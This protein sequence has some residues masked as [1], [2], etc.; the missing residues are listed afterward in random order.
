MWGAIARDVGCVGGVDGNT[1]GS[2]WGWY[3][4]NSSSTG[5]TPGMVN[6]I[7][8]CSVDFRAVGYVFVCTTATPLVIPGVRVVLL[9]VVFFGVVFF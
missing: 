4:S 3:N 5:D 6:S 1:L 9:R 7:G 2:G 8:V